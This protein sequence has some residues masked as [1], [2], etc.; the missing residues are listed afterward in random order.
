MTSFD[1]GCQYRQSSGIGDMINFVYCP[2]HSA[3]PD[4]LA[5]LDDL[6]TDLPTSEDR[7]CHVGLVPM[8]ECSRCSL[9]LQAHAAI[10]KA[11]GA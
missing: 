5:A 1:C 8:E 10:A 2:L 3:A 9:I 7:I 6:L 4:M 11:K